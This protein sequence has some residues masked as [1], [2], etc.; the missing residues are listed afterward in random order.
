M[1][2]RANGYAH[3]KW[4]LTLN[5]YLLQEPQNYEFMFRSFVRTPAT[6]ISAISHLHFYK[7]GTQ[8]IM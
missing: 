3:K 8:R 2:I 1:F 6:I 5:L 4:D 7:K